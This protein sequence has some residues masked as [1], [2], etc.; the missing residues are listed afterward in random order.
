MEGGVRKE[1]VWKEDW[2]GSSVEGGVGK[3]AVWRGVGKEV[4]RKER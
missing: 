2:E 4:V 1:V 3:E